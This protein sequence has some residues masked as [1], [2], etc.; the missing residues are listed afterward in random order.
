MEI[1]ENTRNPSPAG[2]AQNSSIPCSLSMV[3]GPVGRRRREFGEFHQI[4]PILVEFG[5]MLWFFVIWGVG[6]ELL[7][8]TILYTAFLM[9]FAGAFL[10]QIGTFH[11]IPPILGDFQEIHIN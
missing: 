9:P 2:E 8:E 7:H 4:T 10:A 5:E 1:A 3:L 11:Q 6:I